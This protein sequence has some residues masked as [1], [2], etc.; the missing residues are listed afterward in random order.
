[1][2]TCLWVHPQVRWADS[3]LH[4]LHGRAKQCPC[5][6]HN[7]LRHDCAID[8]AKLSK[9]ETHPYEHLVTWKYMAIYDIVAV[10]D[11]H[12]YQPATI[13][14]QVSHSHYADAKTVCTHAMIMRWT[15]RTCR[16]LNIC[17][18]KD[19]RLS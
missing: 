11:P 2:R 9:H 1:M 8:V 17:L 6:W 4:S 12:P 14:W 5:S 15:C 7:S 13:C 16:P 3:D 18:C 10:E 19:L